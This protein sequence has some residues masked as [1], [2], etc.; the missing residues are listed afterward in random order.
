MNHP[1]SLTNPFEVARS[2]DAVLLVAQSNLAQL[3]SIET[4]AQIWQP[5]EGY[6]EAQPLQVMLKFLYYVEDTIP[7]RPWVEP[8]TQGE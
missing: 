7:P 3:R 1:L 8:E 4:Q 5:G 6:S 2:G